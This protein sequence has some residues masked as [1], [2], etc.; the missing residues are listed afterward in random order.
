MQ[1]KTLLL[2]GD[3]CHRNCGVGAQLLSSQPNT[4]TVASYTIGATGLMPAA[5]VLIRSIK[6]LGWQFT[7]QF[8][9]PGVSRPRGGLRRPTS[10]QH[11][12]RDGPRGPDTGVTGHPPRPVHIRPSPKIAIADI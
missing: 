7:G 8:G 11:I 9:H 6:L 12:S 2:G 10:G 3:R 5:I 1:V 4:S